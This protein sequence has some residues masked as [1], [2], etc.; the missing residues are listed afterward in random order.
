MKKN[1]FL[2]TIVSTLL[3]IGFISIFSFT[4]TKKKVNSTTSITSNHELG[5]IMIWPGSSN[6]IPIGWR[7]CDGSELNKSTYSE[8]YD[9]LETYWIKDG[10]DHKDFFRLPDLRGVF[11][12]GVNGDRNDQ[13][14]D[15]SIKERVRV[16]STNDKSKNA[17]GSFQS[18]A[19]KKHRHLENSINNEFG[20]GNAVHSK[21]TWRNENTNDNNGKRFYTEYTGNKHETRP[22]NAYVHFIIYVGK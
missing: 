5:S 22:K 19:L 14:K 18:D 15:H 8:L 6:R 17:P 13:F 16:K 1:V 3:T 21:H 4:D 20:N 9:K 2:S 7:L 10:G 12:R 11:I